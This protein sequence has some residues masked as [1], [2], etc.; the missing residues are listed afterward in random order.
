MAETRGRRRPAVPGLS[1]L[2]GFDVELRCSAGQVFRGTLRSAG[3][4]YLGL[5]RATDGRVVLVSR[6]AVVAL[7][8]E[9]APGLRTASR[10]DSLP[11]SE[12]G[13][14]GL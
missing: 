9:V 8:D 10:R 12:G 4:E 6:S 1:E 2:V 5:E 13:G 7:I 3:S 14:D 11:A